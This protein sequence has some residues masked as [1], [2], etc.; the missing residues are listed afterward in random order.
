MC[1]RYGV[2][3]WVYVRMLVYVLWTIVRMCVRLP[4]LSANR[5]IVSLTCLVSELRVVQLKSVLCK[6][7]GV[8]TR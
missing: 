1:F 3:V 8:C 6:Q 7:T 2:Y 4:H 5:R